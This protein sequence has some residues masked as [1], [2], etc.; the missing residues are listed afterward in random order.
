MTEDER[1]GAEAGQRSA[2]DACQ[3]KATIRQ[4]LNRRR[5]AAARCVP[6]DCGCG[7]D[8][9]LCRCTEPPL[10]HV[11][12]DGWR[13][14]ALHILAA[15]LMPRLPVEVLRALYRRGGR[16]QLLAEL[17]HDAIGGEAT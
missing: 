12:V 16:D 14:S 4:Q 1:P 11:V 15:G 17:L 3:G 8:P 10:S 2:A 9:W 13:A 6:L 7:P 5:A